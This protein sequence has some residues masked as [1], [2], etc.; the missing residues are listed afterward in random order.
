MTSIS[1][2]KDLRDRRNKKV[3]GVISHEN[4]N[5]LS[6]GCFEC[7]GSFLSFESYKRHVNT[8]HQYQPLPSPIPGP[9]TFRIEASDSILI[10][11][12]EEKDIKP[13][14]AELMKRLK[15][16]KVEWNR[17]KL[18]DNV[19]SSTD[20]SDD[21]TIV[22]RNKK[23]STSLEQ[24]GNEKNYDANLYK[25]DV[26]AKKFGSKCNLMIHVR[27]VHKTK[28]KHWCPACA[29]GCDRVSELEIHKVVHASLPLRHKCD[30]CKERFATMFGIK[31]HM[32]VKHP[33]KKY[34]CE[35]CEARFELKAYLDNHIDNEH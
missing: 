20:S 35:I 13:S 8:F 19:S 27:G 7:D 9:S 32:K 12:D 26:C 25:C 29:Y 11:S 28:F 4:Q 1:K 10:S 3:C 24:P 5:G 16:P 30:V 18:N 17:T 23:P 2:I 34:I 6:F 15:Q 31:D 33:H 21:E 22:R 14:I